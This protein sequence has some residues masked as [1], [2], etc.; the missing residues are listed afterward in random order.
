M[1]DR[2]HFYLTGGDSLVLFS[3]NSANEC[4]TWANDYTLGGNFGNHPYIK[5]WEWAPEAEDDVLVSTLH[6]APERTF[7]EDAK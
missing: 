1:S 2:D 6:P 7:W 4:V 5:L 3:S